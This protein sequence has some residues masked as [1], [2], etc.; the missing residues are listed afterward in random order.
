MTVQITNRVSVFPFDRRQSQ[1][2]L[3]SAIRDRLRSN[4]NQAY[5]YQA[6]LTSFIE[7]R[8]R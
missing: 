8:M 2:F 1:N 7:D 4:G 3:R 5:I 6:S